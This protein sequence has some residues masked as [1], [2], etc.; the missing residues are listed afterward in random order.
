MR[1]ELALFDS[2]HPRP[3]WVA[4]V[5]NTYDKLRRSLFVRRVRRM[6]VGSPAWHRMQEKL[7]QTSSVGMDSVFRNLFYS[8]TL[9]ACGIGLFV[10]P[11]VVFYYPKNVFL[12]ER[13]FINR[14]T[15]FMAPVPIRIGNDV[16]IGPYSIFNTGSHRYESRSRRID[17]QGHKYGEIVVEDDVWIGAHVCILPGVT[18]STGAVVAA[19]AVVT[20]SVAPFTVVGGVPARQIAARNE[21]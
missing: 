1:T 19:G 18:L 14:G 7:S 21:P 3:G 16:L 11:Q 5:L 9:P 15:Y 2:Q 6:Q 12:G 17:D 13:V 8:E 20:K 10:H 4:P